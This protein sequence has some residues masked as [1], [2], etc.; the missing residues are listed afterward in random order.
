MEGAVN[1]RT[2]WR[3]LQPFNEYVLGRDK[4]S[5]VLDKVSRSL[6]ALVKNARC[7]AFARRWLI[8]MKSESL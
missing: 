6:E 7:R 4:V 8:Q 1:M 2:G 3:F 5:S